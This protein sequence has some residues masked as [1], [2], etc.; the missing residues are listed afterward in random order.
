MPTF[1]QFLIENQAAELAKLKLKRYKGIVGKPMMEY[2]YFHKNYIDKFPE[3]K[4]NILDKMS[5]LPKDFQY[6][7]IRYN[8]K[9]GIVSFI[10]SPNFDLSDEPISG[11]N[12][13]V[14]NDGTLKHYNQPANPTI[15]HHKWLWVQDDYKGFDV[16]RSKERSI[17][18]NKY[19]PNEP[20]IKK[21]IGSS[22]FWNSLD[23]NKNTVNE[24]DQAVSLRNSVPLDLQ[25]EL[26]ADPEVGPFASNIADYDAIYVGGDPIG[27]IR[28]DHNRP[29]LGTKVGSI[30]ILP[31]FRGMGYAEK[32][33]KLAIKNEP[34][35]TF[36]SPHNQSSKALFSK[37]GF[38]YNRAMWYDNE[39]IEV[40]T[41]D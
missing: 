41:R 6:N 17:Y 13:T 25:K 22:A 18:W 8:T 29:D 28:I 40:W 11:E 1:L 5:Y 39:M 10:N 36:I 31:R 15:W 35:Y 2:V 19:L 7:T 30:F 38:Q 4:A 26:Q 14:D 12:Y 23:F 9:N 20:G 32:A 3:W 24:N 27:T 37:L 34:A 33:I 16:E 21:R